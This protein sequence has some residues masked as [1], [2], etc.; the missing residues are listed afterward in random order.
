[1][2]IYYV[3]KN[4]YK[5]AHA[6]EYTKRF[7]VDIEQY[8][9]DIPEIQ[10]PTV[11]EVVTHK[12][13]RAWDDLKRPLIVSDS[14]WEIPSLGGFP[15]PYMHEINNWFSPE[16]F[17]ALMRDKKERTIILNHYIAVVLGGKVKIFTEQSRG[18]FINQPRGEGSAL[19]Q[20][21]VM[22]ES[23]KTIAENTNAGNVSADGQAIWKEVVEYILNNN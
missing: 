12:A 5:L 14:G 15:G 3:T 20:V 19:D 11:Y 23:H 7:G 16:D 21:V 2:K 4:K 13:L 8:Q 9:T 18:R 6:I 10:A 22:G 17:L 1:M